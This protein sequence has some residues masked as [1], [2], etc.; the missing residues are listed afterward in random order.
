MASSAAPGNGSAAPVAGGLAVAATIVAVGFLGSRLLGV[1]RQAAI[2]DAFGASP[3]LDAYNVAFRVPDLIFQLLAGAT[4]ASAFIPVFSRVYRRDSIQAGWRLA[5]SILNLVMVGTAV[6]AL[7]A[8]VLAPWIV[9]LL[10]PGLGED[11]ARGS[12]LTDKAVKL[13]RILLLSPLLLATSGIVTGILNGRQRF[14]LPALSPMLYN[15]AIIFG[16][17]ALAGR[18]G[19]EGL[20]AGVI[21]GSGLHLAVQIPGLV[22]ERMRYARVFDWS[23]PAVREVGRLMLP[24]MFGLA[25]AQGNFFITTTYFA[26]RVG[27]SAISNLTYAWFLMSLPVAIFGVAFSIAAFPRLADQA[28][29]GDIEA[30]TATISKVM[31]TIMF[32]TIPAALGLWLLAEPTT[33]V[34]FQRGEF[35]AFD[36]H[37]VATALAFYCIAIVPQAGIEIHSRGFYALS[38]T[39]TPVLLTIGAMLVNLVLSALLWEKYEHEGLA[40]SLAIAASVEWVLLYWLYSRRT[41]A[42]LHGDI[43]A[44]A[45]FAVAGAVMALFVSI[46]VG[47]VEAGGTTA[48]FVTTLSIMAAGILVYAAAAA[49]LGLEELRDAVDRVRDLL[50]PNR[51]VV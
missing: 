44:L 33:V 12:E 41:G 29:D 49:A 21:I 31:R 30:M 35:T 38:D 18:W 15:L 27:S 48:A 43:D 22:R 23:D 5:S 20:A 24:R 28:A 10:A 36:T 13:T 1:I 16:A 51:G 14:L 25:A 50:R 37:V 19:V 39:R 32:L 6:L 2:A 7:V 47:V 46:A 26:S 42:P 9:P 34:L 4:L 40:F 3:E 8:F 17:V 45:K 11:I